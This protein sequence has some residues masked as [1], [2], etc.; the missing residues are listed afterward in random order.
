M[1]NYV[2]DFIKQNEIPKLGLGFMRLPNHGSDDKINVEETIKMVDAYMA[3]G[4]N[5]FDTAYLYHG[6]NSETVLRETVVKRYDRESFILVDKLPIWACET[7]E[8]VERVFNEQ[9]EKCG[10][11]YFDIYLL[12]AL[13]AANNEKC[14]RLGAYE[15]CKR[16]KKEG[17][18]KNFGFSFHGTTED[19]RHIMENHHEQIDIVQLQLN[20][21]DWLG[22]YREQYEIVESYKKP[23]VCMEPVRGG[24][25][26]R[27]PEKIGDTLTAANA[28][29]SHASWAVR[30]VGSL[31][32]VVN[33]LSGM[34]NMQQLHDN[35]NTLGSFKPLTDEEQTVIDDVAA[36]LK[37]MPLVG[38]TSCN[39]CTNCPEGIEIPKI[40]E[41]YNK[42]LNDR[43]MY[44]FRVAYK[45][46]AASKNAAACTACGV[47]TAV[48]P[49]SIDIP[50]YMHEITNLFDKQ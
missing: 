2:K 45:D 34:S 50:G 15:F 46:I 12:H 42:F 48:C 29:V 31:P 28:D 38:C 27:L 14:E 36:A 41:L 26:A 44:G 24:M 3:A 5:Y 43:N 35:I 21:F 16:M 4:F 1:H 39:Y 20:Y 10:V 6:G 40:F 30:W 47:C 49:Q 32:G 37:Q 9:L 11:T 17:K 7:P 25:L 13:N 33:V 18:I 19:I 22:M 8:D 23:V